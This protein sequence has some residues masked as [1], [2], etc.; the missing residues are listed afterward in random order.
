MRDIDNTNELSIENINY[1]IFDLDNTLYSDETKLFDQIEQKIGNYV[2]KVLSMPIDQAKI[3]QKQLF[4]K[5]GSTLKG[6]MEEY[7]IEP[8]L[9]LEEVHDIVGLFRPTH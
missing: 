2:K 4:L 8:D 1:W 5:Y 6:L 3:C 7:N 9:F